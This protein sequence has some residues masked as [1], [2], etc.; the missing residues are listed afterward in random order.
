MQ[1]ISVSLLEDHVACSSS[2]Y[3]DGLHFVAN[4][5]AGHAERPVLIYNTKL[6]GVMKGKFHPTIGHEGP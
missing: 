3:Q 2:F 5:I 6:H 4:E 1:D